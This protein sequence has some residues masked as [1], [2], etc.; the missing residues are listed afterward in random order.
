MRRKSFLLTSRVTKIDNKL[1]S[2][3]PLQQEQRIGVAFVGLGERGRS[4]LRLMLPIESAEVAVLCDLS[5]SNLAAAQQLLPEGISPVC[6]DGPDAYRQAC[7]LE[8]VD[9]VYICTDWTSHPQIA[10]EAMRQGKDVAIEVPAATTMEEIRELLRTAAASHRR[11]FLLENAC[12]E[13]QLEDAIAAIRRG[14]IGELV[15]AEGNYYHCLDA[16]WTMWRLEMNRQRRG[17]LYPTHELGP[18][19]QA[20]DIGRSD[21][22]ETL[23]CMDSSALTGSNIYKERVRKEAPDFQNGDHT[24]T[25]IRTRRGRTILL[26]HDVMTEQ[27]YDRRLLFIGTR[28]CI[29]LHDTGRPSHEEMTLEMNR[30]LIVALTTGESF[31]IDIQDLATWCSIIPLS[32]ES[33]RRGFAPVSIPDFYV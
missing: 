25:L 15:H 29:E 19:C 3:E 21:F 18:I 7:Q 2:S 12:F 10:I 17:D 28:G 8:Q 30:R 11:C 32:E 22:L 4:S 31:G 26:R 5:A 9:L 24:T 33:L 14:D 27:P 20:M 16:R 23:V 6:L 13:R 1:A